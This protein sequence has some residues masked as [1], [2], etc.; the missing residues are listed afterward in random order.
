MKNRIQI[1]GLATQRSRDPKAIIAAAMEEQK[2][3]EAARA[4]ELLSAPNSRAGEISREMLMRLV[5]AEAL[6]SRPPLRPDMDFR[7]AAYDMTELDN[8]GQV[9]SRQL[10][11]SEATF[12][13]S[14]D[15]EGFLLTIMRAGKREARFIPDAPYGE[16][17]DAILDVVPDMLQLLPLPRGPEDHPPTIDTSLSRAVF[18]AMVMQDHR[19]RPQRW[20]VVRLRTGGDFRSRADAVLTRAEVEGIVARL[21]KELAQW[22]SPST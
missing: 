7:A 18:S 6:G 13:A 1:L 15:R 2:V 19:E 8:F 21:Q 4:E 3:R 12:S 14:L 17:V 16:L 5:A 11:G 10:E 22:D 20:M 9:V